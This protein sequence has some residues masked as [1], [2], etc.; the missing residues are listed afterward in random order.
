MGIMSKN[1]YALYEYIIKHLFIYG[2]YGLPV[3][4]VNKKSTCFTLALNAV[5]YKSEAQITLSVCVIWHG[6]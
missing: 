5:V 2:Q 6:K 1:K 3:F 4:P